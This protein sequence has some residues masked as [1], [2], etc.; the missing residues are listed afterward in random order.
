MLY[1]VKVYKSLFGRSGNRNQ[2]S[3]E[4][5]I[6]TDVALDSPAMVALVTKVVNW[7]KNFHL[8]NVYFMRCVVS[9]YARE[10]NRSDPLAFRTIDQAGQGTQG[11]P[12]IQVP[13]PLALTARVKFGALTG[14]GANKYYRG[15]LAEDMVQASSDKGANMNR[16]PQGFNEAAADFLTQLGA[17]VMRTPNSKAEDGT[18]SQE[19]TLIT[20]AGVSV[21]KTTRRR[22]RTAVKDD[23]GVLKTAIE[24]AALVASIAGFLITK[25]PATVA[26]ELP[27]A[28]PLLK[29]AA[30]ALLSAL[31]VPPSSP[32]I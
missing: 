14:R 18:P 1:R 20:I 8:T 2:W 4:Y 31:G 19:V 27:V 26:S 15:V 13:E 21:H 9:T 5:S 16:A 24:I 17:G 3:N 25:N 7:E 10:A 6:E 30:Q 23:A 12:N 28:V 29:R 11:D 32:G 22:K